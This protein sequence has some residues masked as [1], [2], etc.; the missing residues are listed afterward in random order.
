LQK[1]Q[2]S[3]TKTKEQ[4]RQHIQYLKRKYRAELQ[5]LQEVTPETKAIR[6]RQLELQED[7]KRD[8]RKI[9][10]HKKFLDFAFRKKE[11]RRQ[12]F[13]SV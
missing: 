13:S 5:S 2:T 7:L 9:S 12:I 4:N 3:E 11:D 8:K 10:E 6:L 1:C